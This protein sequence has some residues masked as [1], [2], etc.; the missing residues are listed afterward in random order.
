M[1]PGATRSLSWRGRRS[2]GDHTYANWGSNRLPS[3]AVPPGPVSNGPDPS[4]SLQ[5]GVQVNI[6][7]RTDSR[8][9]RQAFAAL[10]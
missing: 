1:D 9:P 2:V 3:C 10:A 7:S 6:P 4:G 5:T 8:V